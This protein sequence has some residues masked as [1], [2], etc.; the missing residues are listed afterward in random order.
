MAKIQIKNEN[1]IEKV[2]VLEVLSK[3]INIKK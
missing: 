1:E 3:E 2:R